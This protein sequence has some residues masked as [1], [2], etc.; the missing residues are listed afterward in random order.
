MSTFL[1]DEEVPPMPPLSM[2]AI[3]GIAEGLLA[4]IEPS[5]LLQPTRLDLARWADQTLMEYGICV[6]P[7]SAR[8]LGDRL[9]A[10]DPTDRYG[11]TDILMERFHFDELMAGGRASNR[12]RGTLVHELGHVVLHV[13]EVR[14]RI[15]SPNRLLLSRLVRRDQLPPFRDPE[16]QAWALGGCIVAPRATIEMTGSRDVRMLAHIFG[17]STAFMENHLRRLRIGGE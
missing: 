15:R 5:A 6:T 8:E 3:E 4:E 10:T 9:A 14:E 7:A 1:N 17:V 13:P 12:A 11:T 2:R 16:W